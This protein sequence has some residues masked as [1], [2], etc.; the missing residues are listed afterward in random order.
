[1]KLKQQQSNNTNNNGKVR[2]QSVWKIRVDYNNK[3]FLQPI[4]LMTYTYQDT[5][6][7][8]LNCIH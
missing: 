8:T 4:Q 3:S 1:M 2:N 7:R 5:L 6:I